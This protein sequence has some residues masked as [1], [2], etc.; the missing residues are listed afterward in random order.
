MPRVLRILNRFNLGGPTLNATY[1]T[2]YLAPDFE[3]LLIGG[4]H[5]DSEKNSDYILRDEGINFTT[6]VE[7]KR[8]IGL[9]NDIKAYRKLCQIIREFKPDIVHT[10]AA[11]AGALGR[12]AAS[13]LNVPVI[14]HTFHGHVFDAYFNKVTSSVYKNIERYLA[15]KSTKII[16]I[17]ENQKMELCEIHKICAP[18]KVEVIP[19][20]IDLCKFKEDKVIKRQNFRKVYNLD[21]DEI[22]IGIIGRLVPIKNHDLFLN[23]FK[24]I[25]DSTNKKIRAFIIG[26]GE[27]KEHLKELSSKLNLDYLNTKGIPQNREKAS[28]TFTSWIK[29]VD[30]VLAGLDIVAMTSLNEG[31]PVSLIE[32]QAACKAIV[33]TDVGGVKNVVVPNETALLVPN[34]D[35]DAFT[36]SMKLLIESDDLRNK[37]AQNSCSQVLKDKFSYERLCNDMR[38]LYF[39]LLDE[40]K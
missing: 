6:L 1:L 24:R 20:G 33:T 5:C 8:A 32:A 40:N 11:K 18:E 4:Q 13:H 10:H 21:D 17:S 39:R 35:L 36:Q 12:M 9:N 31:T 2:K 25:K 16:A 3:T 22:A 34:N 7:M 19:L 15:S 23:S 30:Y 27:M 14:I 29:E 28:V 37:F 26:D 38:K